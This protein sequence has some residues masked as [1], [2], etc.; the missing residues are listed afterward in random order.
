MSDAKTYGKI[1]VDVWK[2]GGDFCTKV[3]TDLEVKS[4]HTIM[5]AAISIIKECYD[6]G[7]NDMIEGVMRNAKQMIIKELEDEQAR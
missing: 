2:E 7:G 5:M 6:S 1:T 4:H 3:T